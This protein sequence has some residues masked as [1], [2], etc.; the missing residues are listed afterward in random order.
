MDAQE[1]Q[2]YIIE[3]L[4]HQDV[5]EA[6]DFGGD[7]KDTSIMKVYTKD[8]TVFFVEIYKGGILK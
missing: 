6:K 7:G 3:G 8:G 1:L 5:A 4:D 2:A